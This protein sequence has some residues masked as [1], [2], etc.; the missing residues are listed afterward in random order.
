[1]HLYNTEVTSSKADAY[2][3]YYYPP[4]HTHTKCDIPVA[5]IYFF[6]SQGAELF[7]TYAGNDSHHEGGCI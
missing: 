2:L 4:P 5:S 3:F 1:M 6:Q 7:L